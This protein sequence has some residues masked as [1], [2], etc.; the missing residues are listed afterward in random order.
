LDHSDFPGKR[1]YTAH[2]EVMS[3]RSAVA[4]EPIRMPLE[5]LQGPRR[6]RTP[7]ESN[8]T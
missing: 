5:A 6:G 8:D 7:P 1:N 2:T 4:K 3:S